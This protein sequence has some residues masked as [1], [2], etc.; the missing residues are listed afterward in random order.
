[1][2]AG[3]NP[4]QRE[5]VLSVHGPLL[6]LAGAGTG[7][8]RVVTC[9]I[10]HLMREGVPASAILGVTF[11]NKAAKE[12]HDR[13]RALVGRP[14]SEHPEISTFHS[15]CVRI[16]RRQIHH[17]GYP[18]SFAIYDRADQESLA[19]EV[20][21]EIRCPQ[22]MLT[23]EALIGMISRWKSLGTT[24]QQAAARACEDR[25]HAAASAYSRYQRAMKLAGAVDFDDLLLLVVELFETQP[26]VCRCEA[27][28]YSHI[29][30]DEYQDTNDLQY[31]IVRVLAADHRNLCVVGDDDQSIYA[32]RGAEVAHILRFTQDW[33]E[34]RVVRLEQNYRSTQ[35][36]LDLAN[37]LI[38]HNRRRHPKTL[39]AVRSAGVPPRLWV[40]EDGE[41]EAAAVV[42]E[43]S[44][45]IHSRTGQPCDFAVLF[46]TNDQPRLFEQHFRRR[47]VPYV[48][49]GAQS[50]FD[51]KEVRDV[52]AYLRVLVSPR[53]DTALRRIINVP[54][55][56]IG[57]RTLEALSAKAVAAR[58]P[59]W[60]LLEE[61]AAEPG[62]EAARQ[63]VRSFWDL[64]TQFRQR[65][66]HEPLTA[67]VI[68]LLSHI[69]Y[70]QHLERL[71]QQPLERQARWNSV[72]E[73]IETLHAYEQ[74]A[75]RPSLAALVDE[76][77]LQ[78][79]DFQP[80]RAGQQ[81]PN[82]VVLM[83]LHSAKGLEFPVVFMVGMEEGLLPHRHAV[84]ADGAAI[85][86]ERRLCYV[87]IT[88]AQNDL[89]LT[90]ARTRVRRDKKVRTQASRFLF[91][92]GFQ[93]PG[94]E[95]ERIARPA[96]SSGLLSRLR[97]RERE[98]GP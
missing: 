14:G 50:F 6:V 38:V 98:W 2:L 35:A 89:T 43:I 41:Q 21:R 92:L 86:E 40:F 15:L 77:A 25:Q 68:D 82:A 3:L 44:R 16:L 46:R 7:K 22:A 72:Q 78:Q 37:R 17:L 48:V 29:M 34:A 19:R 73:L 94:S 24:P 23:P 54:P 79:R 60:E 91:E 55:R 13:A 33:P 56:G 1:M 8:T 75:D 74:Q 52:V 53:D 18:A 70:Q 45:R 31:R 67:V 4:A 10:A 84:G 81:P 9:R 88:R 59:L 95:S 83:T 66:E 47:G 27:A 39:R 97:S 63:A 69:G 90:M 12:M 58:R 30:V 20:L 51:R 49:V 80:G 36:I 76:L 28:R 61:Y 11:T 42:G 62:V 32:F 64:I 93:V 71:Y 57:V 26:E 5:A 65:V 85:D 96:G 87:G